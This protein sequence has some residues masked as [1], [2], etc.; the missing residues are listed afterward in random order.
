M[1]PTAESISLGLLFMAH[2]L[3][4]DAIKWNQTMNLINKSFTFESN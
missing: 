2:N 1:Q 4:K 3:Q